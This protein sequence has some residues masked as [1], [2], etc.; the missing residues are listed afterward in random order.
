VVIC[1]SDDVVHITE[2]CIGRPIDELTPGK[3]LLATVINT[4]YSG[5]IVPS[6][7]QNPSYNPLTTLVGV[8]NPRPLFFLGSLCRS[9][10]YAVGG[11]DED[12][13]FPG[14]EDVWFADCLMYGRKLSP[15]FSENII[16]HHLQHE[17]GA[18]S[19]SESMSVY[20]KKYA[21]AKRGESPWCSSGGP[22]PT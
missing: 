17:H 4:D 15:V 18:S 10:L 21:A 6:N 16:G 9:D 13:T 3:F 1:Q 22:W 2:N 20:R 19:F 8:K 14:R 7:L 11:N 5:N 12:F